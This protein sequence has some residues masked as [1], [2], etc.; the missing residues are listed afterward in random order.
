MGKPSSSSKESC[1]ELQPHPSDDES[2][3]NQGLQEDKPMV[4][5]VA[6]E[7]VWMVPDDQE[8]E[9]WNLGTEDNPKT[10]RVNKNVPDNFK[11]EARRTFYEFKDVFAWEHEDLKG[12]DPKV[13]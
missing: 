7:L 9:E 10:I 3:D 4:T 13:C 1:K 12:V 6:E 8:I 5:K 2:D 11:A